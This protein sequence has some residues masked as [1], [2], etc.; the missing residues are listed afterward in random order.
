MRLFKQLLVF[1]CATF[2]TFNAGGG[3]NNILVTY[4]SKNRSIF[5]KIIP[6]SELRSIASKQLR[7]LYVPFSRS[8]KWKRV[9]APIDASCCPSFW[10]DLSFRGRR[11]CAVPPD[12]DFLVCVGKAGVGW[13]T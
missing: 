1:S 9:G 10:I 13:G 2:V 3:K 11:A 6:Y 8:W 5:R 4:C 12:F 7:S